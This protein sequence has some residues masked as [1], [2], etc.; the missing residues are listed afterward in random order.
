MCIAV[1]RRP[2][3]LDL[4][5]RAPS[6]LK[7]AGGTMHIPD[8]A[9][10]GYRM[11]RAHEDCHPY[12]FPHPEQ[13]CRSTRTGRSRWP[14]THVTPCAG[15]DTWQ[16]AARHRQHWNNFIDRCPGTLRRRIAVLA[17]QAE[18]TAFIGKIDGW[19]ASRMRYCIVTMHDRQRCQTSAMRLR[20]ASRYLPCVRRAHHQ[21]SPQRT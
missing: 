4:L 7:Q 6:E 12:E 15:L 20:T 3:A 8:G 21:R 16:R 19:R 14:S 11:W 5:R 13:S 18:T 9:C 1:R 2:T 10:S 17:Q